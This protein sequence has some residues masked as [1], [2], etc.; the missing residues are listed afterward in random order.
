MT[1]KVTP[2]KTALATF[3]AGCF[4][5][6]EELFHGL[7]GVVNTTVGY[8]GGK[9][10]KPTY[11]EVCA[12]NTGHAEAIEIEYDP[13]KISYEKLLAVFWDNHNPST[14]NQQGLDIGS[15]YRSVI[16]YHNED[17]HRLAQES[18]RVIEASGKYSQIVTEIVPA[19]VF[20][21]AE[22][23]H[24]KYLAKRGLSI[25]AI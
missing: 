22:E 11:E 8:T 9:T 25:C 3:G 10:P 13:S 7:P 19:T 21:K 16:F 18:K 6:V 23:Y 5:S 12:D 4:W 20:Y 14:L 15:Q 1:T 24:Q 2:L 17:Q